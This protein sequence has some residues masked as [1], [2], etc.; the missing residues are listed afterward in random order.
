LI[1]VIPLEMRA[2]R[3]AHDAFVAAVDSLIAAVARVLH[4][5]WIDLIRR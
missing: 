4:A 2:A 3:R 5:T 1:S